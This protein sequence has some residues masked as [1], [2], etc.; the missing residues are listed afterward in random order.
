M[1]VPK[2]ARV[3]GAR[4]VGPDTRLLDLVPTEPLGFVGGQFIIVDTRLVSG[5]GKAVKRAYSVVTSDREQRRFQLAVK[6]I[7]RGPGSG[8]L[9]GLD[10]GMNISFSGPWGK[11]FSRD[12]SSGA[13][14]VLASDTGITAALGLVQG[15]RF[16]QLLAKTVFV[17]LQASS[18]YFL[19]EA[20]VREQIP[21]ACAGGRIEAI[22]AIDHP[23]RV[24]RARAICHDVM[25]RARVERAFLSGDGAVNGALFQDLLAAGVTASRDHIE[26]FFNMRKKSE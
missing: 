6:R 2:T 12:G 13:T 7:P 25:S 17:W 18:D 14:L 3:V 15:E 21:A 24:S 8:F 23:D 1:A 22:S 11:F 19:G 5:N 4:M 16:T 10:V 26:S 9:H 20:W